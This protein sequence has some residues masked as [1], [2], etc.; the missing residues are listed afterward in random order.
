MKTS[1]NILIAFL[2]NLAFAV[3]ECVGGIITGSVA[4][5]S[6]AVHDA[7]DGAGRGHAD[8]DAERRGADQPDVRRRRGQHRVPQP[9]V[10]EQPCAVLRWRRSGRVDRP[11]KP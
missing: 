11:R 8:R 6:D 7:G 3:F 5:I 1:R 10:L 9:G 4:T 2:L